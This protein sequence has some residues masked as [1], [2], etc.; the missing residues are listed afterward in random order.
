MTAVVFDP[1]PEKPTRVTI[2]TA[3]ESARMYPY[4]DEHE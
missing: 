4:S 1:Q 2:A 3:K